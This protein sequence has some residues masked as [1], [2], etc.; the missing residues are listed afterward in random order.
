MI[1][2]T[3]ASSRRGRQREL[4]APVRILA[5]ASLTR[6]GVEGLTQRWGAD[7]QK[8]GKLVWFELDSAA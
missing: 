2:L 1:Q 3:V 6:V 5:A 8:R 7:L 4:P